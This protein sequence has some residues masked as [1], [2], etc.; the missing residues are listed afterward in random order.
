MKKRTWKQKLKQCL[1]KKWKKAAG[2]CTKVREN[3]S[4]KGAIWMSIL[5][6]N[7]LLE[8]TLSNIANQFTMELI[9]I[10]KMFF[11]ILFTHRKL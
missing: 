4:F 10:L 9:S 2:A 7:L 11:K 8:T 6:I 3:P 1:L 5:L